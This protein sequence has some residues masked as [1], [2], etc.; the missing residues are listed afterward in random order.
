MDSGEP[1]TVASLFSLSRVANI[2]QA[3][4]YKA[5]FYSSRKSKIIP[6]QAKCRVA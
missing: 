3:F 6:S 5:T 4:L 2:D 1:V